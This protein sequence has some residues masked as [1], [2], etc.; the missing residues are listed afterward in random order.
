MCHEKQICSFASPQSGQK[1]TWARIASIHKPTGQFAHL[2]KWIV[3]IAPKHLL[4]SAVVAIYMGSAYI[5]LKYD[6]KQ[7]PVSD[8]HPIRQ[9]RFKV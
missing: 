4:G 3:V 1:T 7:K 9:K 5:W 2:R 8:L 6:N